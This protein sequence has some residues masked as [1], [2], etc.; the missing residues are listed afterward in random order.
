MCVSVLLLRIFNALFDEHGLISSCFSYVLYVHHSKLWK[1][2]AAHRCL[3]NAC[4]K[5]IFEDIILV[6]ARNGCLKKRKK[7]ASVLE[8][9]VP[10][11]HFIQTGAHRRFLK[12]SFMRKYLNKSTIQC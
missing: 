5:S 6:F 2:S 1:H 4:P 7:L 12:M 3:V 9:R 10:R 8:E 11:M